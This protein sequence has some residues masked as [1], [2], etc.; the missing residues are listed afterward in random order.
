MTE[1]P[2]ADSNSMNDLFD[3][4]QSVHG[5]FV[6]GD[7][8]VFSDLGGS[9]GVAIGR[10]AQSSILQQQAVR[11]PDLVELFRSVYLS[12]QLRPDEPGI[13]KDEL[14]ELVQHIQ[15]EALKGD[16]ANSQRL[17]RWLK[18]LEQVASDVFQQTVELLASPSV[19]SL[20]I[21]QLVIQ[22]GSEVEKAAL[23][24]ADAIKQRLENGPWSADEKAQL[25]EK[26]ELI[27]NE[28]RMGDKADLGEVA[29]ALEQLVAADPDLR[30]PLAAWLVDT[31]AAPR[32]VRII[33]KKM[34]AL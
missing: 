21:H 9:S 6:G 33:A 28:L 27:R 23:P 26:L 4:E 32:P 25:V 2:P 7:K 3:R 15:D 34:L 24:G 14:V 5:D 20:S 16:Q 30:Q 29:Y 17:E 1:Q 10:G 12:I 19:T 31:E 8:I 22:F 11:Q 13:G 18:Q